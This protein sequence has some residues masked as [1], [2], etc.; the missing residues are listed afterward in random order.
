LFAFNKKDESYIGACTQMSIEVTFDL[1]SIIIGFI[2]GCILT[3]LFIQNY[4]QAREER[5]ETTIVNEIFNFEKGLRIAYNI[6]RWFKRPNRKKNEKQIETA[7][8]KTYKSLFN[9]FLKN[10]LIERVVTT[11][12]ET[13]CLTEE[14]KKICNLLDEFSEQLAQSIQEN[15][16]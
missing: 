12:V 16:E 5:W 7:E 9:Y 2:F 11:D 15:I 10:K 8:A 6:L 3:L 4:K 13:Y 1:I 14:G